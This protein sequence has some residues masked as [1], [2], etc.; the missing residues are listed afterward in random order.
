VNDEYDGNRPIEG[1]DASQTA[2]A[3]AALDQLGIPTGAKFA[4]PTEQAGYD[5]ALH[6][7]FGGDEQLMRRQMTRLGSEGFIRHIQGWLRSG[8]GNR[9]R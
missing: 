7:A 8:G 1:M 5:L 4:D 6:G 9:G 2:T 3:A